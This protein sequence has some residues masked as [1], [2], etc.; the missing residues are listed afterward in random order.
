M[1]WDKAE[2][3]WN[4]RNIRD[5]FRR[6]IRAW[7][8]VLCMERT[9]EWFPRLV[10]GTVREETNARLIL[11]LYKAPS[12][13]VHFDHLTLPHT[14]KQVSAQSTAAREPLNFL[15]RQSQL[16]PKSNIA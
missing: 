16:F 14:C 9:Y 1:E 2:F 12:L 4:Y 8:F 13:L 10:V 7:K 11:R 5:S 3:E 15:D 6:K